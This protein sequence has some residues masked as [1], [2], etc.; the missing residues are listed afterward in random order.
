[1]AFGH[2]ILLAETF[3]DPRY[4]QGTCYKAAGWIFAGHS[5]GFARHHKH[6]VANDSPKMV[7]LRP[8]QPRARQLLCSPYLET[9]LKVEPKPMS[10]SV[11]RSHE[12]IE[13]LAN[14]RDPRMRR[15]IRHKQISVLAIAICAIL[16]GA[17]SFA[18]IAE[19]GKRCSANMLKR[20]GC[21]YDRNSKKYH[22][23]SE[24]TIRRLLQS[25]DAEEVDT[26][27]CG[28]L[29]SL[30]SDDA[31]AVDGKTLR[32]ARQD[33]GQKVHLLSAFLHHQGTVIAQCL[34][35]GKTNEI[36]MVRTLLDPVQLKG[37]V[38]TAD[39]MHTQVDTARYLV[40]EKGAH[41]LFTVKDN[42]PTL[43]SDIEA[44]DLCA[45]PPSR[46]NHR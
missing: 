43:K 17:R 27:L 26:I 45:F 4:F 23:P 29:Q 8:I 28:W 11:Q 5:L 25:A 42:Q 44:L 36:P 16:S 22:V 7:F 32:G 35:D 2:P 9:K 24:P 31:V 12:L 18:A 30:S 38:V 46:P 37:R 34:V 19:W 14:L 20:I 15:G 39:A 3:V 21:R 1:C 33:N 40:E 13:R 6:Y 41:Y 10:L